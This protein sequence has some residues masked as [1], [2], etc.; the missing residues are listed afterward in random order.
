MVKK[1]LMLLCAVLGISQTRGVT[2]PTASTADK[3]IWYVIQFMNQGNVIEGKGDGEQAR[4][5][6]LNLSMESS[7]SVTNAQLWKLEGDNTNGY[8]LIN[9]NGQYLYLDNSAR[10]AK[11]Y[12]GKNV[13]GKKVLFKLMESQAQGYT[14]GLELQ[15]AE[16]NEVSINQFGGASSNAPLGLWNKN[17]AGNVLKFV[18]LGSSNEND[19]YGLILIQLL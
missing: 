15:P 7:I 17:D 9:K 3:A 5:A 14:G 10:D 6:A 19:A 13:S 4:T 8:K 2:L 16:N 1:L 18:S 12:A 11:V